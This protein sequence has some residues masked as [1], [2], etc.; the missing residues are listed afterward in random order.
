MQRV[1]C[2]LPK[3]LSEK[4]MILGQICVNFGRSRSIIKSFI[5]FLIF[6]TKNV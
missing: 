1:S 5:E 3:W 2:D 6:Q 4:L